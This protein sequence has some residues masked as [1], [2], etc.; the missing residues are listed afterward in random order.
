MHAP[1]RLILSVPDLAKIARLLCSD[2][3]VDGRRVLAPQSMEELRAPQ[4]R[5]GSVSGDAGRG[6]GVAFAP[7][8]F[9]RRLAIGH[10]G[11]AY[12][13]NAEVWGDPAT[14]DAV[15]MATNGALLSPAGTLIR[16]GWAATRIGFEALA[17][18]K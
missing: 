10:Q 11:V 4:A 17:R 18:A 3:A 1:G 8:V 9:G 14:G 7:D 2:G 16:C 13:M 15:A 6:L 12:G 5:R